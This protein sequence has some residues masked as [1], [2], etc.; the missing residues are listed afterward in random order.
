MRVLVTRA[1][2]QASRTAAK[3]RALGHEPLVAPLSETRP[4]AA[5]LRTEGVAALAVAPGQPV[6]AGQAICDIEGDGA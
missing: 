3:L 4:V 6:Q 2:P 1:E 5:G